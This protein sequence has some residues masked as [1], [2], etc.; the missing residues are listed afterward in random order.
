V[1][2]PGR[3]PHRYAAA[4]CVGLAGANLLRGSTPVALC[5]G[6]GL[7]L[8]APVREARPILLLA[9][10]VLLGWWWGSA[11]LDALDRSVLLAHVDTSERSV[12]A[13]NRPRNWKIRGV[14][15]ATKSRS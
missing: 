14:R 15:S 1:N 13:V 5:L 9:A 8:A 10:L 12:L 4:L 6:V 11:R 7:V 3:S 2:V